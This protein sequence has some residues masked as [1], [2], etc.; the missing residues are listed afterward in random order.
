VIKKLIVLFKA[1]RVAPLWVKSLGLAAEGKNAEAQVLLKRIESIL[2]FSKT[3][4]GLLRGHVEFKLENCS[5]SI[6]Y[7]ESAIKYSEQEKK[8]NDDEKRYFRAYAH[9]LINSQK[10]ES[11]SQIEIDFDSIELGN[12]SKAFKDNYPLRVHPE[13]KRNSGT[14]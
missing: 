3:E 9:W 13:W 12:I 2:V 6:R 11:T 10:S 1:I 8:C 4:Y 14:N 5:E 7:L